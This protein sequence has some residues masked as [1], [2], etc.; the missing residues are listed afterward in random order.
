MYEAP[1]RPSSALEYFDCCVDKNE[2]IWK[3]PIA[4]GK[5]IY[6]VL[7]QPG[8]KHVEDSLRE[9]E[10]HTEEKPRL[11][12]G[13]VTG[14]D[15]REEQA[16]GSEDI[17]PGRP[18]L[19]LS[20]RLPVCLCLGIFTFTHRKPRVSYKVLPPPSP[21]LFVSGNQVSS[22]FSL[23]AVHVNT[24]YFPSFLSKR[25]LITPDTAKRSKKKK[26]LI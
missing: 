16:E 26:I 3:C 1:A 25:I 2:L 18:S 22:L 17:P 24:T 5:G 15:V 10:E 7:L 20:V 8:D 11:Q 9:D 4:R 23:S 14:P 21:L 13:T 12:P 19:V 6:N